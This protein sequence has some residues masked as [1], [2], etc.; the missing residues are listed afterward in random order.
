[1]AKRYDSLYDM[2]RKKPVVDAYQNTDNTE[3]TEN[4]SLINN[5]VDNVKKV[6]K[7]KNL[8]R[9]FRVAG[10]AVYF[11]LFFPKYSKLFR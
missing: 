2:L 9:K 7:N 5:K 8:L 3:N 1:M 6:V 4:I 11:Y 10:Y